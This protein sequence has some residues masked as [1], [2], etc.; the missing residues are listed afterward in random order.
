MASASQSASIARLQVGDIFVRPNDN[1]TIP[2]SYILISNGGGSTRWDNLSS[3]FPVSSFK[4]VQASDGSTFSADVNNNTLLISTTAIPN[5][6]A[7]YIDQA[8][9]SVMLSLTFPPIT[10]NN[11]SVPFVTNTIVV[12]NPAVISSIS[13]A[14]TIRFYGLNDI[15]LSTVNNSQAVYIGISSFTSA[16]YS[17]LNGE[18][19]GNVKMNFSTFSTAMGL[20]TSQSFTSSIP[21]VNPFSSLFAYPSTNGIDMFMS[22]VLFDASHLTKYINTQSGATTASVEFFPNFQ[23]PVLTNPGFTLNYPIPAN[24]H[25]IKQVTSYLQLNTGA[26]PHIFP[27][28]SNIR[29]INSQNFINTPSTSVLSNC[30]TDSIKMTINPYT[31]SSYV[32]SNLPLSTTLALYHVISSGVY[33]ESVGASNI[34]FNMVTYPGVINRSISTNSLFVTIDNQASSPGP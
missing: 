9:S 15:I 3:I 18:T 12:P 22:S 30:F 24:Q 11:G 8:T 14:S 25:L 33:S 16:G 13:L 4:T 32:A 27:E 23:F 7:S 20:P 17:T 6:F 1:S 21:F 10:I 26:G 2:Q 34:G 31:V 19:F 28:T 5:T 29:F